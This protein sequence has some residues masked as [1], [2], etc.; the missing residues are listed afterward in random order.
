[1][2]NAFTIPKGSDIARELEK[3]AKLS[4]STAKTVNDFRRKGI[5]PNRLYG[6][7]EKADKNIMVMSDT[8]KL[9]VDIKKM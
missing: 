6:I 1:M 9:V 4:R 8:R 2:T 3:S 5:E 7:S